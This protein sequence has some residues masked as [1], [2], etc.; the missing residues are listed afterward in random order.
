MAPVPIALCGKSSGMASSFAQ[1]ML[2]EYEV[3]HHFQSTTAAHKELPPLLRG[4]AFTPQS[5]VGTDATSD[6]PRIPRAIM[7]GA[8]FS[9]SELAEMQKIEGAQNVPWLYPD[10]LKSAAS[11]L[12]GPFLMTVIVK[13]VKSCLKSNGVVEGQETDS[14]GTLSF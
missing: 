8:G 3:V 1:S 4:E 14:K 11:T 2:P 13:R 6:K 12:S 10:P 5:D 7:V 9:R